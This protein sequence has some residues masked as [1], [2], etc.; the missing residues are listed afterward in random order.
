MRK[1]RYRGLFFFFL[2]LFSFIHLPSP[3]IE[4]MRSF[5]IASFSFP[6]NSLARFRKGSDSH[7]INREKYD[8]ILLE[9]AALKEQLANVRAWIQGE[10]YLQEQL[11]L[12]KKIRA[13]MEEEGAQKDFFRR[14]NLELTKILDLELT[15]IPG[16]VIFRD[17][18]FWASSLW[19]N[20][21]EKNNRE[22]GKS[23]IEK[24]SPVLL[25]D[26]IVGCIE[27][28]EENRSRVR[29][30]TDSALVPS[31][32]VLR[33]GKLYL[34]KGEL[35]GSGQ[36]FWRSKGQ[37]LK[38]VGFNYDFADEEGSARDLRTGREQGN[39]SDHERVSLI[40]TGDLL[41]TTG[42]DGVFPAGFKVATVTKILPLQEGACFYEIEALLL[43]G[44]LDDLSYLTVLPPL[45]R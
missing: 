26:C 30:I 21:G 20:V 25:G 2:F 34:A 23:I 7:K 33:D 27:H 6:W 11:D 31:V 9:N 15:A 40:E 36:S 13:K 16:K 1:K 44:N 24:N 10:Q 14:R 4:R 32:R 37:I 38:G 43:A 12:L 39:F 42:M 35:Y 45:K 8:E 18:S 5:C 41:V 17:P 22:I 3:P 19:L 29:L 28:V